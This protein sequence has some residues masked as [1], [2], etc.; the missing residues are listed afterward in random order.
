MSSVIRVIFQSD[1]GAVI[2]APPH[3]KKIPSSGVEGRGFLIQTF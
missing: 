3:K 2:S 1:I